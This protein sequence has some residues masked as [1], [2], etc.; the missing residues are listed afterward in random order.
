ML[1]HDGSNCIAGVLLQTN[2]KSPSAV[3]MF[4][5]AVK[6]LISNFTQYP[7]R[8]DET[9]FFDRFQVKQHQTRSIKWWGRNLLIKKISYLCILCCS[10]LIFGCQND[11]KVRVDAGEYNS[12]TYH[13]RYFNLKIEVPED[14]YVVDEESRKALSKI[15]RKFLSGGNED[16]ESEVEAAEPTTL[17]LLTTSEHPTGAPVASNPSLQIIAHKVKHLPGIKRGKDVHSHTKENI[18]MSQ[19]KATFSDNMYEVEIDRV[20]FD[21]LEFEL[22]MGA[23]KIMQRQ[24]CAILKD[25]ALVINL[26]Y[27]EASGLDKLER[28]IKSITLM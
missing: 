19:I 6:K 2:Q 27:R 25:Y 21:V 14:W 16:Y 7:Y 9:A 11:S 13:N 24:Y 26:T 23:M 5:L 22:E 3:E 1:S 10:F 28:V 15:G 20:T 12:G 4:S 17:T 8:I 18:G